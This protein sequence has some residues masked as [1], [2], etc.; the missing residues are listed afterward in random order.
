MVAAVFGLEPQNLARRAPDHVE[1]AE[2]GQLA[3]AAAG[4]D[5]TALL[6]AEKEG[7]VG[8]RV[9]VVEQLEEEAEAALLAAARAAL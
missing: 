3:R 9:V 6:I 7:R 1:V 2:P 5:Q 4:A 8:R